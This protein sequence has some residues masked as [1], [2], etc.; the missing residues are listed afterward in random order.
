[1]LTINIK[2]SKMRLCHYIF[3]ALL[4]SITVSCEQER[5]E[6][7]PISYVQWIKNPDNGL[8]RKKVLD[9]Y[10]FGVQYKPLEF[11]IA[12]YEKKEQ[13]EILVLIH[14]IYSFYLFV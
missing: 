6:L 14:L 3:F 8:L 2:V 13:L 9:S 10:E 7:P 4:L 5:T 1:M 11:I 12:Q